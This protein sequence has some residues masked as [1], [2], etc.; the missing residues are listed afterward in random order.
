MDTERGEK[1]KLNIKEHSCKTCEKS[2]PTK[3]R[4]VIHE[5]VHTGE[6]PYVCDVCEKNIF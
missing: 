2:F 3:S 5:R 6:K 4:L 1:Q